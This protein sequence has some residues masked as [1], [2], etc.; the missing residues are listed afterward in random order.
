MKPQTDY[1][2]N[3]ILRDLRYGQSTV[4]AVAMRCGY[5]ASQV[6]EAMTR[7]ERQRKVNSKPI[8]NGK[9]TVYELR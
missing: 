1:I 7:L 8:N 6:Q 5:K 3:A 2:A 4:D 9:F